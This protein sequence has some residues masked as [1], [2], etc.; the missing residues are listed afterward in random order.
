MFRELVSQWLSYK[1]GAIVVSSNFG[2]VLL[3]ALGWLDANKADFGIWASF[4]LTVILIIGHFCKLIWTNRKES[5]ESQ[6]R[7]MELK[8]REAKR[9]LELREAKLKVELLELELKEKQ[10]EAERNDNS[11]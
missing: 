3:D 9:E 6:M 5:E 8:D 1:V 11:K 4:L 7:E 2:I 10:E